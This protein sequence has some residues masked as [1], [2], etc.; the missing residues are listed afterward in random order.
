ME[1]L[2]GIFLLD[3]LRKGSLF[4]CTRGDHAKSEASR[5]SAAFCLVSYV[6]RGGA[7]KEKRGY[8]CRNEPQLSFSARTS[9]R[10]YSRS[11]SVIA[12]EQQVVLRA[13][14]VSSFCSRV[15]QSTN[16][17]IVRKLGINV[18]TVRLWRDRWVALQG[19]EPC[20]IELGRAVTGCPTSWG[21]TEV[22]RRT[23]L[24]DGGIG[25]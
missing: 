12:R 5:G 17:Q 11:L 15:H 8:P 23:A 9:R 4:T 13:R 19:I 18:D 24:S 14:I 6:R 2:R 7:C 1:F 3:P 21:E 22:Y 10:D 20:D 16:T 25:V